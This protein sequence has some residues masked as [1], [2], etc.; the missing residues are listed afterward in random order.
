MTPPPGWVRFP[1]IPQC[2]VPGDRPSSRPYPG[3][4]FHW[5]EQATYKIKGGTLPSDLFH[6]NVFASFQED[7]LGIRDRDLIGIDGLMWGSDYPHAEST[8]AN[9]RRVIDDILAG[10]PD[11]EKHMIVCDNAARLYHFG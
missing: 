8:W 7:D 1:L 10:V 3:R 9:S 2:G 4:G 5:P 11:D 6:R